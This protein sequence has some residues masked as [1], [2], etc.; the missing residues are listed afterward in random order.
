M[1]KPP[2]S[3]ERLDGLTAAY[4]LAVATVRPSYAGPLA[5]LEPASGTA[6][7]GSP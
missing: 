4:S 5:R 7:Q 2:P 1:A 3:S 6:N